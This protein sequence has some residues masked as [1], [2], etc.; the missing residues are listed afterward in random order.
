M[1]RET[2][3]RSVMKALSWRISG[4]VATTL[5]V[6][7]FTRRLALSVAVGGLEFVSK[8]GLFWAHERIWDRL[9][10]GRVEAQPV[11]IWFTGLSGSGKSTVAKWVA[12]ALRARHARVE[13]LDGD[14][15]R[16]IFPSTGFS[17]P[18]R[19][20][21]VRRVGYLASRLEQHGVFV[22]AAFVSPYRESRDFVRGLCRNF[23]EVHVSTP[24][25]VCEQR[26]VKGLY[27]RARRGEIRQFTGID[28]PYEPPLDA[29]LVIDTSRMSLEE[30]GEHVLRA[31][32]R[33]TGKA[34]Q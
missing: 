28:D 3:A 1:F 2:H 6:F 14:T 23:V 27:A 8:I 19:D 31:V 7:I 18:E 10:Y 21:H 12:E 4:T 15:I 17:K 9:R 32:G 16:D 24:L 11:V 13:Q 30:A 25:E 22:V 33:R 20:A 26:D 29:E 34:G 5:L